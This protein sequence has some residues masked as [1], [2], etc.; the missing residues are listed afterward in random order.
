MYKVQA[1]EVMVT[2]TSGPE[3][4][5]VVECQSIPTLCD[6]ILYRLFLHF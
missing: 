5:P 4:V 3:V 6:N 1:E 2:K